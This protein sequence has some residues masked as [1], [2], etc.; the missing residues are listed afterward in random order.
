MAEKHEFRSK[1]IIANWVNDAYM[2]AVYTSGN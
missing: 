2:G 1:H